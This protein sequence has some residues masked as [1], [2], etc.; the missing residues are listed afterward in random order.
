M[1][2]NIGK[3]FKEISKN[4][5]KIASE[6]KQMGSALAK[7]ADPTKTL[8]ASIR[9]NKDNPA[10]LNFL[11]KVDSDI[12]NSTTPGVKPTAIQFDT[13]FDSELK[14]YVPLVSK[15]I[16]VNT[17]SGYKYVT[18]EDLSREAIKDISDV[19]GEPRFW[20]SKK[21]ISAGIVDTYDPK[22]TDAIV[23]TFNKA[24]K[25]PEILEL[26]KGKP[27][28]K[29]LAGKI[30]YNLLASGLWGSTGSDAAQVANRLNGN[31]EN[32]NPDDIWTPNAVGW[33]A[34]LTRGAAP[35]IKPI[36]KLFGNAKAL[37]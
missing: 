37:N 19:F 20:N 9:N 8:Q 36:A 31:P 3:I 12:Q 10:V 11:K 14:K 33:A 1:A 4:G 32:G 15:P 29:D 34:A 5:D 35:L 28:N 27:F 17:D 22:V 2:I 23:T 30:A 26:L 16:K 6:G 7:G 13:T 25:N 18:L 21:G 24:I